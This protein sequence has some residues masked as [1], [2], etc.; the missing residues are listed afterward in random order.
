MDAIEIMKNTPTHDMV[1]EYANIWIRQKLF[2]KVGETIGGHNINM[3]I[4]LSS[5]AV[6]CLSR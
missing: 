2:H 3:T 1:A 6:E 5:T 4:C